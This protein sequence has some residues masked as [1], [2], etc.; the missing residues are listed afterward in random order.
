ME[1]Q[2]VNEFIDSIPTHEDDKYYLNHYKEKMNLLIREGEIDQKMYLNLILLLK[3]TYDDF[4][5]G[6]EIIA[7]LMKI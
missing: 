6:I 5:F 4:L 1:I 3:G 2:E 7:N